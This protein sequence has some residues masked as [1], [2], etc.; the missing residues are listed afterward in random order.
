MFLMMLLFLVLWMCYLFPYTAR[1]TD[2][3]R[4]IMK[5]CTVL[6]VAN[7][8]WTLLLAVLLLVGFF[9]VWY[10]PFLLLIA[11]ALLTLGMNPVLEGIFRKY[12]S[13]E[14]LERERELDMEA[15]R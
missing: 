6:A 15:K 10:A 3:T 11:P 14:D 1:F 4:Q 5:N 2:T 9:A 7:L 13:E 8:P 12:M